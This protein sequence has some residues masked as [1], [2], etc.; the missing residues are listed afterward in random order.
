ML[1]VCTIYVYATAFYTVH[2]SSVPGV[3]DINVHGV[4]YFVSLWQKEKYIKKLY[5]I[6]HIFVI[7]LVWLEVN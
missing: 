6:L 1:H 5:N 3:M 4:R 2:S 7:L